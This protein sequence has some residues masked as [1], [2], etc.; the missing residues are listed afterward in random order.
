ML[1]GNSL[2]ADI[3]STKHAQDAARGGRASTL[4][5]SNRKRS[6][7]GAC[8]PR[9]A[10]PC[11]PSTASRGRRDCGDMPRDA[12]V[13]PT[14]PCGRRRASAARHGG[15]GFG[16]LFVVGAAAR[17][18]A[19]RGRPGHRFVLRFA[20][21]GG[22]CPTSRRVGLP[23]AVGTRRARAPDSS[24][25]ASSRRGR[26]PAPAPAPAAAAGSAPTTR[27]ALY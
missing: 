27:F 23:V 16:C 18:A 9:G 17:A 24:T 21:Y 5:L 2:A 14:A 20:L 10:P 13:R 8:P 7:A 25:R 15:G 19:R 6:V 1:E 22:P 12:R 3:L 4:S 26:P 11:R